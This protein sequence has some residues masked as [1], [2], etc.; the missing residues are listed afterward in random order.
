[1]AHFFNIAIIN[2]THTGKVKKGNANFDALG[3][4]GITAIT[5]ANF[6]LALD[7]DTGEKNYYQN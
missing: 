1:M 6:Y 7:E 4:Q 3:S 5:R 2:V